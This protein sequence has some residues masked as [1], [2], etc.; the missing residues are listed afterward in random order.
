MKAEIT[1]A[2][3]KGAFADIVRLMDNHF[4]MHT[5]SLLHLFRDEQRKVLNNLIAKTLD[6]FEAV[7]RGIYENNTTLMTFLRE[8][9]MPVPRAYVTAVEFVLLVDLQ[10]AFA[11]EAINAEKIRGIDEEMKRW[12]CP[13]YAKDLEFTVKRRVEDFMD[14]ISGN[15]PD[16]TLLAKFQGLLEL[17]RSLPLEGNF[18]QVQNR[19]YA[20]AK[21][22]FREQFAKAKAGDEG[23]SKWVKTFETVGQ[24]LFF[25]TGAVLP[26]E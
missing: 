26:Q 11:E 3:K 13:P 23:A 19:Y 24:L 10:K 5:Y 15:P 4:G 14:R 22:A 16:E 8:T 21:T 2:F 18:W 17:L 7:Y 25:N 12:K 9:G 20:L 6:G 1:T